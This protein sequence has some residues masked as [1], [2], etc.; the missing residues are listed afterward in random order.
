MDLNEQIKNLRVETGMN[1]KAF[2]E[3][4]GIPIRTIE[5]WET[6]RRTPPQYIPRLLLYQWKYEQITK[7][8]HCSPQNTQ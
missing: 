8:C 3:H 5:D 7:K 1:R 2:A 4:F 6:A